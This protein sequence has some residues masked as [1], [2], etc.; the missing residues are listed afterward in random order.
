M[1]L[2]NANAFTTFLMTLAAIAI[3]ATSNAQF[4]PSDCSTSQNAEY[5]IETDFSTASTSCL[6]NAVDT[7]YNPNPTWKPNL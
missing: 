4:A 3:P 1:K 2:I 7:I 6:Q 5:L